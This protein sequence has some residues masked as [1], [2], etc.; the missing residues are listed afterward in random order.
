MKKHMTFV[1][2]LAMTPFYYAFLLATSTVVLIA[3]GPKEF[4][5]FWSKN[6]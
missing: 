5:N 4:M 1:W 3:L 6:K 2:Q